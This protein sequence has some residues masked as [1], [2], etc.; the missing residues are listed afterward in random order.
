MWPADWA[1]GC[2]FYAGGESAFEGAVVDFAA[3]PGVGEMIAVS[4][5]FRMRSGGP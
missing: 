1:Y 4:S 3:G 5:A 2:G